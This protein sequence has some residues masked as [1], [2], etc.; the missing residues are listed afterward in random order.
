[1]QDVWEV[2]WPIY[3]TMTNE[4]RSL[5]TISRCVYG[6]L[7]RLNQKTFAGTNKSRGGWKYFNTFSVSTSALCWQNP[8]IW[9]MGTLEQLSHLFFFLAAERHRHKRCSAA[10]GRGSCM[11]YALLPTGGVDENLSPALC[12]GMKWL[13]VHTA[14]SLSLCTSSPI[15]VFAVLWLPHSSLSLR[16]PPSKPVLSLPL[17]LLLSG[18]KTFLWNG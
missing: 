15:T 9:A 17:V 1:M 3:P 18:T 4:N 8:L 16:S 12:P 10:A 13:C 2:K 6:G 5:I 11:Q 14:S 7:Q